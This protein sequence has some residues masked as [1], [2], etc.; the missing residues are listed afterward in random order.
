MIKAI[1]SDWILDHVMS[2]IIL[3]IKQGIV[4]QLRRKIIGGKGI[5]KKIMNLRK[6]ENLKKFTNFRKNVHEFE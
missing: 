2:L 5:L 1:Q 4:I 6:K 3:E